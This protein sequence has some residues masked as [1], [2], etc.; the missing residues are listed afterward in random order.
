MDSK[1][2]KDFPETLY[3][4]REEMDDDTVFC[5]QETT[6]GV[7][8]ADCEREIAVYKLVKRIKATAPTVFEDL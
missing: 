4:V 6:L 8:D 2:M 3:V 5:A 7:V 1:T